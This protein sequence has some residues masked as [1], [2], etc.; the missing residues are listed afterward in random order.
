MN[1][2][3]IGKIVNTH[4][5]K[6]EVRILSNFKY[7]D[8]VFI[9]NANLYVGKNKEKLIINSY[10]KHKNFDQVT[11]VGVED[12]NE[13]L[14]YKG[15]SVYI[16]REEVKIDGILNEDLIG[17]AVFG[18]NKLIGSVTDIVNNGVYDILVIDNKNLVPYV[19]EFIKNIDINNKRIDISLIEGLINE[20]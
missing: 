11:F 5:I 8:D 3:Y 1:F 12:I 14:M 20:N 7:K 10:R 15:E 2:I 9:K 6:G 13:V 18:N 17:I 4:G 19:D 16:N